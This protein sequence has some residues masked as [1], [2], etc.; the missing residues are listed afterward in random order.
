MESGRQVQP[1]EWRA[2]VRADG[3]QP[4]SVIARWRG[5]YRTMHLFDLF[6]CEWLADVRE[7][8]VCWGRW[9]RQRDAGDFGRTLRRANC[10]ACTRCLFG[11]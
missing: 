4:G 5:E 7:L 10:R 11:R 2:L 9:E 8:S 3:L 6:R 1:D